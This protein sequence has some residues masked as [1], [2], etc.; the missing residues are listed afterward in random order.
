MQEGKT[1]YQLLTSDTIAERGYT[2]LIGVTYVIHFDP[3][4][5]SKIKIFLA[6]VIV[7]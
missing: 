3:A 6:W 7:S 1:L 2:R 4:E 5:M